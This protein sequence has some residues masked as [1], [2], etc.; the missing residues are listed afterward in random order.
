MEYERIKSHTHF[1]KIGELLGLTHRLTL[2]RNID[3]AS[4]YTST[5]I[6]NIFTE[7]LI[8]YTKERGYEQELTALIYEFIETTMLDYLEHVKTSQGTCLRNKPSL[9][10]E[11]RELAVERVEEALS[12]IREDCIFV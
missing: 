11:R 10:K 9:S 8:F 4:K 7:N 1:E 5:D 2:S 12:K 6:G 3:T